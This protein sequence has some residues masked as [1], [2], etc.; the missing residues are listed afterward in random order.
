[1]P[2]EGCDKETEEMWCCLMVRESGE[3]DLA[4]ILPPRT[5]IPDVSYDFFFLSEAHSCPE[6]SYSSGIGGSLPLVDYCL[7]YLPTSILA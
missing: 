5:E 2:A 3:E 4:S 7:L 1:M 6:Y